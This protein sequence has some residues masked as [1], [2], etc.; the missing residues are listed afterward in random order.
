MAAV[1]NICGL[2]PVED[3]SYRYKMPS[4]L[5]RIEGRG[6]GIKTVITNIMDVSASLNREAPVISVYL[7]FDFI[8][9]VRRLQNF[10][11]VNLGRK[12]PLKTNSQVGLKQ[13]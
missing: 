11:V 1:I 6:N 7:F 13:S 9:C 12:L 8:Y 2:T 10:S 3:P 5:T 4:M